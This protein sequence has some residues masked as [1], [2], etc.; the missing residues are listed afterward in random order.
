MKIR[1][2]NLNANLQCMA[3]TAKFCCNC[4]TTAVPALPKSK[5]WARNCGSQNLS[6]ARH[7][8]KHCCFTRRVLMNRVNFLEWNGDLSS[9]M[10]ANRWYVQ[11]ECHSGCWKWNVLLHW[12]NFIC[13]VCVA[14]RSHSVIRFHSSRAMRASGVQVAYRWWAA[15]VRLRLCSSNLAVVISFLGW[16]THGAAR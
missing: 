12:S 6:W 9:N 1:L 11:R 4:S 7:D 15:L 8:A 5:C 3:A 16:G 10:C 2:C 14:Q 13:S